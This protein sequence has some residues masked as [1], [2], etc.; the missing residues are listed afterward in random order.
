MPPGIQEAVGEIRTSRRYRLKVS[1]ALEAEF[2]CNKKFRNLHRG[3]RCF[4]LAT[5]P[6]INKQDLRPLKGEICIAVS[7][8]FLHKDYREISPL[9]HVFAPNHP[10]Y[11]DEVPQK[12]ISGF[13]AVCSESTTLF[14]GHAPYENSFWNFLQRNPQFRRDN[15]HYLNYCHAQSLNETNYDN[16][17]SWD[18]CKTPFAVR[19]VVYS[20]IQIAV[21]M[22]FRSIYLLGV[23]FDYVNNFNFSRGSTP[24]FYENEKGIDDSICARSTEEAFLNAYTT[25]Q[26]YRLIGECLGRRGCDIYN[27]TEG[28]YLDVYPRVTLAQAL[29]HAHTGIEIH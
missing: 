22:G 19:T 4:I 24:H 1:H 10:P 29:S 28:G 5:G 6:S 12:Y 26:Q 13:N 3:E 20:A 23:E 9:Y 2:D 11:G 14:L 27:A 25:L 15:M 16:P 7:M 17:D 21:Y 8:F 18:I